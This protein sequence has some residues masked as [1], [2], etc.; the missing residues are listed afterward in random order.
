MGVAMRGGGIEE[1]EVLLACVRRLAEDPATVD[2][3][4]G[5]LDDILNGLE[6]HGAT[7]GTAQSLRTVLS[8]HLLAVQTLRDVDA[9]E[10]AVANVV[11]RAVDGA[12]L[13]LEPVA[14]E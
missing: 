9:S 10:A 11:R 7:S 2:E 1:L 5:V 13:V 14:S 12:E 8:S 6:R 4:V 3:A